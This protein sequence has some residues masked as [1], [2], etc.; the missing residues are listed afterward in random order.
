MNW[1][2]DEIDAC[3]STQD[4]ARRRARAARARGEDPIG[5]VVRSAT[6]TAGRGRL[7]RPWTSPKGGLF[8]TIVLPAPA[9]EDAPRLPL[10]I[11]AA[12]ASALAVHGVEVC[13]RPPNDLLLEG[14]KVAGILCEA[15]EGLAFAGIG[16]N[17]GEPPD[18]SDLPDAGRVP[19]GIPPRDLLVEIL[20]R[21]G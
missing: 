18:P 14:K 21:L 8:A 10:L 20:S 11:G 13:I 12:V 1:R 2:V 6:Q 19:G 4:E 17:L 7:G 9:P 16:V 15:G 3:D 5:W